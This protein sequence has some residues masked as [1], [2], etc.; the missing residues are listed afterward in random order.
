MLSNM[1]IPSP[2]PGNV[3]PVLRD[4]LPRTLQ[5]STRPDAFIVCVNMTL[6]GDSVTAWASCGA[7]GSQSAAAAAAAQAGWDCT[8]WRD[9]T[10]N[11]PAGS[12]AN[13]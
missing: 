12:V 6:G 10:K 8:S 3:T 7:N 11:G 9:N 4:D 1:D 5:L 13:I 2:N